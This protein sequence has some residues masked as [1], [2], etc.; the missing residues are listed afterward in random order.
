MGPTQLRL[1]FGKNF[2][3]FFGFTFE[4]SWPLELTPFF[5][6]GRTTLWQYRLLSFQGRDTKLESF[7]LKINCIQ[8]KSLNFAKS[9]FFVKNHPKLSDFFSL[10]NTNLEPHFLLLIF[11]D[12]IN[13]WKLAI[14]PILK[15]QKLQ[16]PTVD[17]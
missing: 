13:F 9:I 12:N 16:L 7:W 10:K 5:K 15:I 17:F 11:F 6:S 3:R 2:V 1:N 8:I 4:F 14:T